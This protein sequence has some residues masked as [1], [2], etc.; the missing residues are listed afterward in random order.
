MKSVIQVSLANTAFSGTMKAMLNKVMLCPL[1]T[2]DFVEKQQN[3]EDYNAVGYILPL[4]DGHCCYIKPMLL[5]H[6]LDWG[7]K[8]TSG[9]T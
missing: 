7:L 4:G 3:E 5:Y 2:S 1:G 6:N 8:N 9:N